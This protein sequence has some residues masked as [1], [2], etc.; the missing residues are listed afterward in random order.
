[1]LSGRPSGL[2]S[3]FFLRGMWRLK[4]GRGTGGGGGFFTGACGA[5]VCVACSLGGEGCEAG[6]GAAAG[7]PLCTSRCGRWC[8]G[9]SGNRFAR[10]LERAGRSLSAAGVFSSLRQGRKAWLALLCFLRS[11][12]VGPAQSCNDHCLSLA[13]RCCN[14]SGAT[15]SRGGC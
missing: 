1:M 11:L 13:V 6:G 9:R 8:S 5:G 12:G 15:C 4:T 3:P 7:G 10:T 2:I 14:C